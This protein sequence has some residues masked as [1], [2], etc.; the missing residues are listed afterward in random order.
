MQA[1]LAPLQDQI[2]ISPIEPKGERGKPGIG[3]EA[4]LEVLSNGSGDF[5]STI[6]DLSGG[7]NVLNAEGSAIINALETEA[8]SKG[9]SLGDAF[10]FLTGNKADAEKPYKIAQF[11]AAC[12][13]EGIIKDAASH[14]GS[15]FRD[16]SE[17]LFKSSSGVFKETTISKVLDAEFAKMEKIPAQ[18][19]GQ[20]TDKLKPISEIGDGEHSSRLGLALQDTE[21]QDPKSGTEIQNHTTLPKRLETDSVKLFGDLKCTETAARNIAAFREEKQHLEGKNPLGAEKDSSDRVTGTFNSTIQDVN[22]NHDSLNNKLLAAKHA[23][24]DQKMFGN[25]VCKL[26]SGNGEDSFL[27]SNNQSFDRSSELVLQTRETHSSQKSFQADVISQLL[28]KAVLSLKNGQTSISFK[29]KPEALGHLRM[30]VS[31]RNNQV[32]IRILTED[33]LIKEIIESNVNHLRA[34]LQKQGMEIEKFDVSVG[35]G[36][37][38]NKGAS[39]R[40]PYMRTTSKSND[41]K[42]DV[43]NCEQIG[44]TNRIGEEKNNNLI[45]FFA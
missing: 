33:P 30:Q 9:T 34:E 43:E 26:G 13:K 5:I 20:G 40:L 11:N 25:K 6:T 35:H 19:M 10:S 39:E 29:L 3:F 23:L 4:L 37:Y 41:Q 21:K 32:I 36:S 38:Q 12:E 42:K 2:E 44:E 8:T 18:Y 15:G 7:Q 24:I 17:D 31:T 27:S 16:N 45:D 1:N 14:S 28:E 22:A